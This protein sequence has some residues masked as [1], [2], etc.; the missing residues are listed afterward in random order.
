MFTFFFKNHF[1]GYCMLPYV[2]TRRVLCCMRVWWLRNKAR[3]LLCLMIS[4]Q[5][6]YLTFRWEVCV[7]RY[8]W[9]AGGV[10]R[11]RRSI[12]FS[13]TFLTIRS[14][15]G[16]VEFTHTYPV[17]SDS[18]V[19]FL[20][21]YFQFCVSL[22]CRVGLVVGIGRSGSKQDMRYE[23]NLKGF[24]HLPLNQTCFIKIK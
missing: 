15:S 20:S 6:I 11:A 18:F 16:W 2:H 4:V 7:Y 1:E 9:S 3:K 8:T 17:V 10:S 5:H 21:Y 22:G 13:C 14:G 19:L 24:G 23:Y 12:Y